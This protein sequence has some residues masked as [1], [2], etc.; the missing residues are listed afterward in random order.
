MVRI[1]PETGEKTLVLGH[2]IKALVGLSS[3]ESQALFTLFQDRVTQLEHTARWN[4]ELGDVA[5]W[6][7]RATQHYGIADYD[8]QRRRLS[9]I[10]LAGDIPVN[11]HGER[12][13]VI[14]GD[15]SQYS[16]LDPA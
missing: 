2:F 14:E 5:I 13:R 10:T 6:D 3:K 4:W 12:S 15:A 1:H 8:D 7:N 11:I 16:V 9:R